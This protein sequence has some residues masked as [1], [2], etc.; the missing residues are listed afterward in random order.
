M[1]KDG[2]KN[3]KIVNCFD[4]V[5]IRPGR[6][7]GNTTRQVDK[8]IDLLF[9]GKTVLVEDHA[10][11][12]NGASSN[13]SQ[14]LMDEIVKRLKLIHNIKNEYIIIKRPLIELRIPASLSFLQVYGS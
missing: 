9:Q 12:V 3:K 1:I 14:F 4:G 10:V 5:D 8:A 2:Y 7:V 11:I 13:A 6:R